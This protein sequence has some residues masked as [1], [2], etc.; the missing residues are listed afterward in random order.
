MMVQTPD[1]HSHGKYDNNTHI[2]IAELLYVDICDMA[3]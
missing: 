2:T 1:T 3:L